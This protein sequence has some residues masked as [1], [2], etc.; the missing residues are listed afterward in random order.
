MSSACPPI[1][2]RQHS[3]NDSFQLEALKMLLKAG[4]KK[5]AGCD[6]HRDGDD[7]KAR[8]VDDFR[9]TDIIPKG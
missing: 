6:Q 3:P 2:V 9:A 5:A 8:S 7:T 4:S 1:V